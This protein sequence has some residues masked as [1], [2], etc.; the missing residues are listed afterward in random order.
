M[1]IFKKRDGH[2]CAHACVD[3]SKECLEPGYKKEDGA[4]PTVA[5]DSILI[6]TTIDTH[7]GCNVA[8][9]NIPSA[10]LNAYNNKDIIMLLKGRLAELMVQV[11]LIL[12]CEYTIHNNKNQTLLYAKFTKAIYSLLKSALLFYRKI[13]NDLKSYSSMFVNDPCVAKTQL[14]ATNK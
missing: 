8:T 6:F 12:Y 3:D 13:V 10:F 2:V 4:S 5:T 1:N 9:I 11:D 7:K 14:L